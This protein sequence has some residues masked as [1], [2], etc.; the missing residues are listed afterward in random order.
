[1][2]SRLERVWIAA[3]MVGAILPG[4]GELLENAVHLAT[5]GHL[6]HATPDGDTHGPSPAE[7]G[8]SGTLH[9]CSCCPSAAFA[10]STALALRRP[11]D[12]GQRL[13]CAG[14]PVH[15]DPAARHLDHPPRA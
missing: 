10:L 3:L 15:L 2:R 6:A 9:L 13:V 7:H 5:R 4:S 1:M 11:P 12:L 8:C 14:A